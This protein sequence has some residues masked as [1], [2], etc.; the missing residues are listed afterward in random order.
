MRILIV[1]KTGQVARELERL[2]WPEHH[3]RIQIGRPECDLSDAHAARRIVHESA[4]DIVVN[5]A[6]YTAV[7]RAES[8]PELAQKVNRDAPAAMAGAC[9]EVGAGFLHLSTD[10]V[11]DGAKAGAYV[12]DDPVAPLSVYGR[13]KA[14]GEAAIREV[15]ERH[16][17]VRTSWVFSAFGAN[18]VR[19]ML[20]VSS[21]RPEIRV[22]D[23]QRGAPT[24]AGDIAGAILS[25]VNSWTPGG[26][27]WGTFH[28]ASAEPTTWYG[29]A[30]AIFELAG[31]QTKLVP[32]ATADYKTAA[33]RPANSVLNCGR[34]ARRYG[35]GQPAW[36]GALGGVLAEMRGAA[37]A[38]RDA[39]A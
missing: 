36:R 27:A 4:P 39:P 29:F 31:R 15:L 28:F 8:E 11:F 2:R 5:A 10:Y 25:I 30:K 19:T 16:V 24:S 22:V 33:R 3:T 26:G 6:A 14:E 18:F 35:I 21:E 32:I 7:D 17:I 20:R 38:T 12:E 34:I 13:T 1:G 37:E 9:A 23:D